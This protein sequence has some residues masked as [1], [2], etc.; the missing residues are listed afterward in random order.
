[1]ARLT[2]SYAGVLPVL[3]DMVCL[4]WSR[5]VAYRA[6]KLFNS[7]QMLPLTL[8]QLVVQSVAPIAASASPTL[9][10]TTQGPPIQLECQAI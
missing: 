4:A 1:M 9:L 6:W 10:T 5:L 3:L 7:C 8:V 2:E